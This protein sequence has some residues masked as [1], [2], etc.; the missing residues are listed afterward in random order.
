MK[1]VVHCAHNRP[2]KAELEREIEKLFQENKDLRLSESHLKD[3]LNITRQQ[4]E[5]RRQV[6]CERD[7]LIEELND[8]ITAQEEE[9]KEA[10]KHSA[11]L[12]EVCA[13][14]D[15]FEASYKQVRSEKEALEDIIR[16]FEETR[17]E[18]E[19]EIHAQ[20]V[21]K[22]EWMQKYEE[23]KAQKEADD[24]KCEE[25]CTACNEQY[26]NVLSERNH[27][28]A[29]V[30]R[31]T[32]AL[33]EARANL[34]AAADASSY[35]GELEE[36][37]DHYKKATIIWQEKAEAIQ[38]CREKAEAELRD[39]SNHFI[40]MYQEKMDNEKEAREVIADLRDDLNDR[41]A[42][43]DEVQRHNEWLQDEIKRLT[44]ERDTAV[45]GNAELIEENAE[46]RDNLDAVI[47]I[48]NEY[49]ETI[50]EMRKKIVAAQ[51]PEFTAQLAKLIIANLPSTD[52]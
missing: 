3:Q 48:K 25:T 1:V 12:A 33:N 13:Q 20:H 38:E 40:E 10:S 6:I 2:T 18:Y 30:V 23:L 19:E 24:K 37:L 52:K 39:I 36:Q 26:E 46:L 16:T 4:S 50:D 43:V 28:R 11:R 32:S 14:R 9:L 17:K 45:K 29:E 8:Q 41:I 5:V 21:E 47:N 34:E 49:A 31:L 7:R 27:L 44:Y 51:S 22:R 35:D 15:N 42:R